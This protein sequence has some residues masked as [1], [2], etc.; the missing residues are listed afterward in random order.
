MSR[1]IANKRFAYTFT[2]AGMLVA[3]MASL[4]AR[5]QPD[6]SN[7]EF[8]SSEIKPG[9]YLLEATGGGNI[10][11]SVGDDGVLMVDDHL[12]PLSD[13]LQSAIGNITSQPVKFLV[14]T[15]WHFDH[16]GNNQGFGEM[17]SI[18][19]AH[20]NVRY[21]LK[22]GQETSAFGQPVPP[23]P[24]AALPVVTFE[25]GLSFHFNNET[26]EVLHPAPAHTDGDAVVYFINANVAHLGDLFWN[27]MYP[28]VDA[29]SGG[30]LPGM[31]EGVT[32]AVAKIDDNTLVIPGHGGL[33]DK[34]QLL[35]FLAMLETSMQRVGDLKSEGN[36]IEQIIAARPLADL[37]Q[38]WGKGF[39]QPDHWLRIVYSTL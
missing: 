35:S 16:A 28:L 27:G 5:A 10:A 23:S 14:N 12:A 29:T 30:S 19:V 7:I 11:L 22:N 2:F 31:I 1:Y 18:I 6:V 39:I 4:A 37:D 20:E 36:T 3:V 26:I 34:Q 33:G 17:G 32:A 8:N 24:P 38:Q 9:L 15:H 21:R 25:Q 13:K